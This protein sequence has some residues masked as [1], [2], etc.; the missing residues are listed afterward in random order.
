MWVNNEKN[1]LCIKYWTDLE[2][3]VLEEDYNFYCSICIDKLISFQRQTGEEYIIENILN[4]LR[5][6]NLEGIDIHTEKEIKML[7]IV[8]SRAIGNDA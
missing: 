1:Q 5:L 6:F 8:I 2:L 4:C 7:N 3:N